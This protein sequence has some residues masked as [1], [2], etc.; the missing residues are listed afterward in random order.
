M[1]S[2]GVVTKEVVKCYHTVLKLYFYL[3]SCKCK[4]GV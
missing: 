2:L 4:L 1:L 3:N